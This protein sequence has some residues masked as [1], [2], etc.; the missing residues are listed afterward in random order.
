MR[1]SPTPAATSYF[2][3]CVCRPLDPLT[4]CPEI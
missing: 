1:E 3:R 2:R 4:S